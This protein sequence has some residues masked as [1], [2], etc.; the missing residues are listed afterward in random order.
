MHGEGATGMPEPTRRDGALL[1]G[2]AFRKNRGR[3]H[4][5]YMMRTVCSPRLTS[6]F[7]A[8]GFRVNLTNRR[9][10]GTGSPRRRCFRPAVVAQVQQD[11]DI[12]ML[13]RA[14]DVHG[15]DIKATDGA[16]G[17]VDDFLFSDDDWIVRWAVI[18]I[19]N[20][21]P[22]RQVL[23]PPNRL[24]LPEANS[25]SISVSLSR[26]QVENS[27]KI[28]RD[29][30]VS[31]QQEAR[32]Y[33]PPCRRA[34]SPGGFWRR[35][36][37]ARLSRSPVAS[38]RFRRIWSTLRCA[39]RDRTSSPT[40]RQAA[41]NRAGNSPIPAATERARHPRSVMARTERPRSVEPADGAQC[42]QSDARR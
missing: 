16:I 27:P 14:S 31:R 42:H 30:P 23:L 22:S 17:S 41:S 20:W 8:S 36:R 38:S 1:G 2:L 3:V 4:A 40:C 5:P 34:A 18:D 11:K 28:D 39:T 6:D 7:G 33:S 10:P 12:P 37:V 19:G 32:I 21:L 13:C 15:I 9:S 26:E 24:M 25:D 35:G 29:P